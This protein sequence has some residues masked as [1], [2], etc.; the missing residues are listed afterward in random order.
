VSEHRGKADSAK[1]ALAAIEAWNREDLRA[2]LDT[3]DGEAQWRPAFPKGTEGTGG[4][5]SGHE[6]I[7]QA[8]HHVRDAWSIYRVDADE[9]RNVGGQLLALGRIHAIGAKSGVEIHS[10][11]SAAV[12]VRAG[13]IVRAWD[14]LEHAPAL[15]A[16][17]LA[18]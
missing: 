2:F 17:E 12:E 10:E 14:W 15:Q 8:W 18:E 3:L 4:V 5:F 7:E 13:R 16:V 9:A 11:W 1:V 6:E